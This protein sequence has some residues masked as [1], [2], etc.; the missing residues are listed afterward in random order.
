MRKQI[1]NY[2]ITKNKQ[3]KYWVKSLPYYEDLKLF[4]S[5]K[6]AKEYIKSKIEKKGFNEGFNDGWQ[7]ALRAVKDLR[8][9][10]FRFLGDK[11]C[12]FE[13]QNHKSLTFKQSKALN[14]LYKEIWEFEKKFSDALEI[15]EGRIKNE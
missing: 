11:L 14:I 5:L 13:Q 6:D 3:G 12:M 15:L 8:P 7:A 9:D 4:N 10:K 1:K 2:E